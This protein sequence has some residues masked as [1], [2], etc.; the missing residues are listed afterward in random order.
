MARR[1]TRRR[2]TNRNN[3]NEPNKNRE[4]A[5]TVL[6]WI[7][8]IAAVC[9]L[10]F[11]VIY[12]AGQTL[13]IRGESLEDTFYDGDV[14]LVNKLIYRIQEPKQYDMVVFRT[15]SGGEDSNHYFIKRIVATPGDTVIIEDGVLKVNGEELSAFPAFSE[16]KN[17]GL[18]SEEITL[19]EDEYFV[20]GDNCNNSEDSRVASVGNIKKENMIGKVQFKLYHKKG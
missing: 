8:E 14:V 9:F 6:K 19:G 3:Y 20:L 10:A 17:P 16:I 18:A 12:F 1:R 11:L 5:V 15:D 13:T 2:T 4:I 7:G